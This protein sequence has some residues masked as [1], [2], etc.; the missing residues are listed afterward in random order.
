M[1]CGICTDG[2]PP[3]VTFKPCHIT[4]RQTAAWN[5]LRADAV[6]VTRYDPFEYGFRGPDHLLITAERAERYDGETSV[7]GLPP[8]A[9]RNFTGKMTFVPAGQRF[10]GWQKPRALTRVTYFY[11]DPQAPLLDPAV[12][13]A[14]VELKP[15]IFF[16]DA[17]LWDT[18]MKLRAQVD[19]ADAQHSYSEALGSVL[20]HELI[21]SSTG[22]VPRLPIVHGGLATWQ[23]KRV[24]DYIEAHVADNIALVTLANVAQLSPFHFARAFRQSFGIPPHRFHIARRIERAKSLLADDALSITEIGQRLGYSESSAFTATFRKATGR[25]PSDYRR[26]L[27]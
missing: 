13:L 27:E 8:S 17:P 5:G 19:R 10:H 6:S 16:F 21:R 2:D 11:I 1:S 7:E 14:R 12:S 3:T 24:A 20:L 4:K 22:V 25:T 15:R 9:A 23:Q 18:A 26:A